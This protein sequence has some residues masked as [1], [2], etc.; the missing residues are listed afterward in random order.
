MLGRYQKNPGVSH[1]NG[2]KKVLR[3]I[4]GIKGLMLMYE[5]SDSLEIVG[6]SDSDF[7]GWILIDPHQVMY[8]NLQVGLY[9]GVTLSRLS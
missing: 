6:Y 4:Q 1:W 7:V 3:Y 2:I 9:C 5:R 8:S